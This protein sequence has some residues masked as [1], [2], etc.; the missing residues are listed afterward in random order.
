MPR[1]RST[2][3][4]RRRV[5]G[6]ASNG[7][8][9][10]CCH[11]LVAIA[12]HGADMASI[13]LL[14]HDFPAGGTERIAIRLL[15]R[16]AAMGRDVGIVCGSERGPA[17]ALVGDGVD[18]AELSPA[19]DRS[20]TSRLQLVAPMA[21][22]LRERQPRV[23]FAPG[24]FHLPVVAGIARKLGAECPPV[25]V[26]ISNPLVP[27]SH[28]EG[29]AVAIAAVRWMARRVSAF[30]AM[31]PALRDEA[32]AILPNARIEVIGEPV[33]DAAPDHAAPDL[34]VGDDI[35]A[36]GR[37]EPQKNF[38]LAIHAFAELPQRNGTRLVIL[39]EGAQR[40]ML[41]AQAKALGVADRVVFAGH[42][43]DIRPWL[44]QAGLV[45][46]TS[47]YEGFPA[48]A[49]EARGH[50][51]PVVTTQCSVAMRD[52][53]PTEAHGTIVPHADPAVIAAAIAA[54]FDMPRPPRRA[55]T[56]GLAGLA[57]DVA[58]PTWL[59]LFDDLAR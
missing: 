7:K 48:V 50:G 19:I 30:V 43:A 59:S 9:Q 11:R 13:D 1:L 32:A 57:L 44:E 49:V 28:W 2:L 37:L 31:S 42:V 16:W 56:A 54:R 21:S 8:W 12:C 47:R 3:D 45:L 33:F 17:R 55:F 26:K 15:N 10:R 22:M 34:P 4:L 14:L 35:L 6:I 39:G 46:M 27:A 18:V 40:A 38:A 41:D 51:I 53:L 23:L 24:N 20:L 5:G 36:I 25:V 52:I 58:A 29:R